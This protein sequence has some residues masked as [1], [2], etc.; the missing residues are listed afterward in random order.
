MLLATGGWLL[1]VSEVHASRPRAYAAGN[2]HQR[3]NNKPQLD[4]P[5]LPLR[6]LRLLARFPR[7]PILDPILLFFLSH[8]KTS[9]LGAHYGQKR[10]QNQPLKAG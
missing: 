6:N 8:R 1:A 3:K 2:H 7:V 10:N 9:F 4:K 5:P